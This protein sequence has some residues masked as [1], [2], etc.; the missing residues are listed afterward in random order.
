MKIF[1]SHSR[2]KGFCWSRE[3]SQKW[4]ITCFLAGC[5]GCGQITRWM[6][7][8]IWNTVVSTRRF[9]LYQIPQNLC[10]IAQPVQ[11]NLPQTP[12]ATTCDLLKSRNQKMILWCTDSKRN[13][14]GHVV[15]FL[16]GVWS[17]TQNQLSANHLHI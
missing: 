4:L 13:L 8:I 2:C 1:W 15:P 11:Q 7:G 16:K 6:V 17:V 3:M 14:P 10:Q 12:A 9:L 5:L